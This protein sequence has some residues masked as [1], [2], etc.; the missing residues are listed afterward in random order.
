MKNSRV[1][2]QSAIR[3]CKTRLFGSNKGIRG[4]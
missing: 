3:I 4:S 2:E 1:D